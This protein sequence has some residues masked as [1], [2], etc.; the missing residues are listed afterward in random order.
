MGKELPETRHWG[1]VGLQL[2]PL[3]NH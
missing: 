3:L 2:T 1:E